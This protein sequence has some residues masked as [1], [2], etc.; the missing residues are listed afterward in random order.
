MSIQ[1]LGR[2]VLGVWQVVQQTI[3]RWTRNDGNLLATSMAYYAVFSFFPLLYLLIWA[4]GL[5]LEF[6]NSA[7]DA[8][9]QLIDFLAQS[10]NPGFADEVQKL[11]VEVRVR[12]PSSW[13]AWLTLLLG[14][15]GIFS[16]LESAFDR[17]WQDTTPH[18]HGVWSAVRNALWNR[19]KAFLTLIGLSIVII[20]AFAANLMLTAARTWTEESSWAVKMLGDN[21]IWDWL[22]TLIGIG[23][24]AIVLTLVYKMIPRARVRMVHAAC[25]GV[26]V[27]VAWQLSSRLVARFVVGTNYSAYSVVGSF[28]AILLWVYCASSLLFLG[29]QLVQVLGNPDPTPAT[30][31][32][33]AGPN[34]DARPQSAGDGASNAPPSAAPRVKTG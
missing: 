31:L 8:Q 29:A 7:Q 5:V 10:T 22:Q 19:L 4:L 12:R 3:T 33:P 15:I 23:I 20:M 21:A 6:S 17:L 32:P 27:A 18:Q 34:G 25:G 1:G 24:N 26:A 30:P 9:A 28:I 11:L 16:A 14:A 2:I 13:L